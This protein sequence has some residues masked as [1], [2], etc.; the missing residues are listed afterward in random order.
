MNASAFFAARGG[1]ANGAV[2]P[3]LTNGA[4]APQ[5]ADGAAEGG[6]SI[7]DSMLS[8]WL[9]DDPFTLDE[10]TDLDWKSVW[11]KGWTAAAAADETPVEQRTEHGLPVR[12]P[13]ARLVPGAADD[14]PAARPNG[15]HRNGGAAPDEQTA[16]PH[17]DPDSVRSTISSHFGGVHAARTRARDVMGTDDE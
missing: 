2:P 7:F 13:G 4:A 3:Q 8:E 17:R 1:V 15:R 10:S 9:I 16:M 12:T 14:E 5:P 6:G 11:D